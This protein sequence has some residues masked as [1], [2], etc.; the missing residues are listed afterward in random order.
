M[1]VQALKSATTNVP[2]KNPVDSFRAFLEKQKSQL[3]AALPK[4]LTPDRM[5]RLAT[6]EFAK[7]PL[8]Q[9]CSATSIYGSIIQ[10]SQLGLEI[11][12]IGQGYLVPYRNN[13]KGIYECQ[14]ITGYK[15]LI[16]LARRSGEVTS[17][18]THIVYEHDKFDL[19]LGIDSKVTHIPYLDGE[20]GKAKLV[21]GVARFKDG[22]Y[23]FEWMSLPEVDNIRA[24]SKASNNGPWVTDYD[25][26]VR[27][28]LI[29]R[30]ANYLPMSIELAAALGVDQAADDGKN[31]ASIDADF[32]VVTEEEP[33]DSTQPQDERSSAQANNG[34]GAAPIKPAVTVTYAQVEEQLRKAGDIDILGAAA[35]LIGEVADQQQRAELTEI[36]N[37][38]KEQMQ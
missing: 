20:R 34:G 10:A 15:G 22:G 35:D 32:T 11:G 28:T 4:H 30:M 19:V 13:K 23:H 21:Y 36:Y 3:A 12:V 25:Q 33:M 8:L 37:Q 26:M 16:S 38:R 6:T 29:R 1:S 18:E 31:V 9:Q 5:I 27:K 2:A 17:I 24:R 7:N 14:F